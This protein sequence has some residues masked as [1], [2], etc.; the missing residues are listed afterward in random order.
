MVARFG[1]LVNKWTVTAVAALALMA[2]VLATALPAWAQEGNEVVDYAENGA[3]PVATFTAVDPEGRTVYWDLVSATDFTAID[4]NGDGDADDA[5]DIAADDVADAGDFSISMDG[6]LS[7]KF[8]PDFETLNIV[9]R[10]LGHSQLR[11]CT[12]W[13]WW[14]PTTPSVLPL[15]L[16][17]TT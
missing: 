14:P 5:G 2:V 6:V 12:R 10:L 1:Y 3:D 9:N 8:P 4:V 13:S 17:T 11:T 7:F 16:P 15:M